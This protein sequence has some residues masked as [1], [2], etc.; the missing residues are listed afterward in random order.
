MLRQRILQ[1]LLTESS[2]GIQL[3]AAGSAEISRQASSESGSE[4]AVGVKTFIFMAYLKRYVQLVDV[5]GI[6]LKRSRSL[7]PREAA[8]SVVAQSE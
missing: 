1:H 5:H 2:K 8:S 6:D 7:K 4:Y 3:L